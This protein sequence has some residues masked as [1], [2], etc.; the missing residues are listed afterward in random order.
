MTLS[1]LGVSGMLGLGF[2]SIA[3]IPTVRGLPV[4]FNII[5]TL[6]AQQQFFAFRLGRD[7]GPSSGNSTFN[8]GRSSKS[9]ISC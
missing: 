5:S 2:P 3:T 8:I 6:P 9:P 1:Q 7:E 4:I